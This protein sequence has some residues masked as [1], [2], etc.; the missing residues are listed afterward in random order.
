MKPAWFAVPLS[1]T[2]GCA[3]VNPKP[4]FEDVHK[5]VA[6]RSGLS[7]DPGGGEALE[8][9]VHGLL[10]EPLTAETAAQL[11]LLNNPGLQATIEELGVAQAELAQASRPEGLEIEAEAVPFSA[12]L[13]EAGIAL[14]VLD[15]LLVPVQRKMGRLQLEQT[16]LRVGGEMLRLVA[17]V[18]TAFYT[19]QAQ[20]QLASRLELVLEIHRAAALLAGR[21]HAAG[22]INDL[23]FENQTAAYEQSRVELARAR[24]EAR[25]GREKLNRLMG[26]WGPATEWKLADRL[27]EIPQHEVGFERLESIAIEQRFDVGAAR[28]GVD[29]VGRALSLKKGTRFFPIGVEAGVKI[30]REAETRHR[31]TGPTLKLQLPIFDLGRASSARLEAQYRQSQRM[32]ESAAVNARSEVREARDR[33]VAARDQALF[34]RDVLLPQRVRLLDLTTRHYNMMLKGVYDLLL[35]RQNEV[36]TERAYIEAWRDYWI[37]RSELEHAAG[38]RLRAE[39]E[40][41]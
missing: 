28:S 6:E 13:T 21:Q 20:R 41:Q 26:L 23:D 33:L 10:A 30:E 4:A 11:A 22:N 18:K 1:L 32:L 14:N 17:D 25:G 36:E 9:R 37:A 39:G 40:S 12:G 19:Y 5:R 27:P 29:L 15:L 16:K 7:A 24:A 3:S 38:G 2:M 35:A 8:R 31:S 34:Y